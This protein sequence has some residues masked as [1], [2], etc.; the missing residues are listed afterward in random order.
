MPTYAFRDASGDVVL[1]APEFSMPSPVHAQIA[2]RLR[3]EEQ[4]G[5][6]DALRRRMRTLPVSEIVTDVGNSPMYRGPLVPANAKKLAAAAE[7]EGFEVRTLLFDD[8]C[9]IQGHHAERRC[10]FRAG[11]VRGR[12]K[13]AS[14]HTPYR[15]RMIRDERP[16]KMNLRDHVGLKGYRSTGMSETRLQLLGRPQGMKITH[17][18]LQ[19][20]LVAE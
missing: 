11:Y 19:A 2:Q 20:R 18:E 13:Y 6:A 7:A 17:T 5:A 9:E 4:A 1:M 14:W 16:I 12:A 10:G 15:Y 3:A 8:G